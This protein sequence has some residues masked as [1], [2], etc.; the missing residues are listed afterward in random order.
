MEPTTTTARSTFH[1]VRC[2]QALSADD[3]CQQ[4]HDYLGVAHV[5]P[6]SPYDDDWG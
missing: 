3:L 4:C 6:E 5:D 1:D 2:H